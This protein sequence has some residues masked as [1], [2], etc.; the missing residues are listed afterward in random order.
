MKV[1]MGVIVEWSV[2]AP[3]RGLSTVRQTWVLWGVNQ[4][5]KENSLVFCSFR[6]YKLQSGIVI[7]SDSEKGTTYI[8]YISAI[9]G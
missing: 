7:Y 6:G 8:C 4:A 9:Y 1:V 3:V 2:N 5:V